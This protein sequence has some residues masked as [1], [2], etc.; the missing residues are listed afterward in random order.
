MDKEKNGEKQTNQDMQTPMI[1]RTGPAVTRFSNS[2]RY[3]R[4]MNFSQQT[5]TQSWSERKR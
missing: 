4:P 3:G 5:G 2:D 1:R